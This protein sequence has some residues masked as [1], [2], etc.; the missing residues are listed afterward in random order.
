MPDHLFKHISSCTL[1]IW[2]CLLLT[3]LHIVFV[4]L[5]WSSSVLQG[6]WCSFTVSNIGLSSWREFTAAVIM[7]CCHG[8]SLQQL[9]SWFV[10]MERVYNSCDHGLFLWRESTTVVIMVCRHGESLQQLWSWFVVMERVY[11]SCDHG[12]LLWR[13]STTVVIMVCRHGESL[14]QLWSWKQHNT[15]I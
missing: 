7:V 11:N 12:L 6:P 4:E 5:Y 10:V 15:G 14:Q 13:E 2:K 3:Q 9:W 8:E 1:N